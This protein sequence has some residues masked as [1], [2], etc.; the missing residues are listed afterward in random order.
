MSNDAN[1]SNISS[2]NNDLLRSWI[3]HYFLLL[4]IAG[5]SCIFLVKIFYS[6]FIGSALNHVAGI[7]IGLAMDFSE[8]IFYR[9]LFSESIGF[10]GTRY[11]P[12]FF[13]LHALMIKLC[14]MPILS[15]H[16]VSLFSGALL[17]IGCFFL[18]RQ[19][20]VKP[21]LAVGLISLLLSGASIQ[22]GLSTI[23]GDIL[24]LALNIVGFAFFSSKY[25]MKYRMYF[26]SACFVLAFSAKLTAIN[27]IVSLFFWLIL[28]RRKKEAWELLL[29]TFIGCIV[30]LG[31]LYFGTS[32]R[33]ISIFK[34]CS[35]GGTDLYSILKSLPTAFTQTVTIYDPICLLLLFW[36]TII[37]CKYGKTVMSNLLFI[38]LLI[39]TVL[40]IIIFGSPGSDFNHLVDI[41]TA[42]I[43]LIGSTE[44]SCKSKS[45]RSSIYIYSFLIVFSVTYNLPSLT[46][47]LKDDNKNIAKR[48]PQE[49]INLFKQDD[50]K[51][52]SEDPMIPILANK[53]PYLLDPFMLRLIILNS[54]SIRSSVFDSINHKKFS[55][56]VFNADPLKGTEWYSS[57]HFGYD[58]VNKVIYNYKEGIRKKN[59]VVYFPK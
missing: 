1:S 11:F 21:I 41:S 45:I 4:L 17:F 52:L 10:G 13:S 55:A 56:I 29:F 35:S 43:L 9:P 25:P 58:F 46:R 2:Y 24:P 23:R 42:S 28:N 7:W 54:S 34:I 26:T 27:G 59:Y 12:L 22:W 3:T 18:L 40:T 16:I 15:G 47:L 30:F 39:S 53:R 31:I 44:F 38:F 37:I 5:S 49:I 50:V 36:A 20:E 8:G 33:I 51:V 57:T 19:M 14:G 48:Y 32:S 6:I